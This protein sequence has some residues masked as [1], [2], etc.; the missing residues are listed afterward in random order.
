MIQ[1]K[2]NA[3]LGL[4]MR[5]SAGYVMMFTLFIITGC[6][7]GPNYEKPDIKVPEKFESSSPNVEAGVSGDL[8]KWWTSMNDPVLTSL[9]QQVMQGNLDIK[10]AGDRIAQAQAV[11]GIISG[12]DKPRVDIDG[13][14]VRNSYSLN[15]VFGPFLPNRL[16]ND[17]IG[18]FNARWELDLFGKT[19]RSVEAADAGVEAARENK[20]A[21]MLAMSAGVAKE[22]IRL[23]QFQK[24]MDIANS[25]IQIQQ[26]ILD[27]MKHRFDV[28]LVNKLTLQQAEAQLEAA[29][30]VLPQLDTALQQAVHRIGILAGQEPRALENQLMTSGDIPAAK[31][32]VP[33]GL[34]S[35]LL[36]RRPDVVR[37]ERN[38][39]TATANI[40]AATAD[41]F[42]RF[43][44]TGA[45]GQEST[46]FDRITSGASR[47][48]TLASGFSWP[49]L[50]S[51]MIRA[52]IRL[53]DARQQ[54]AMNV[55]IRSILNAFEDVENALVAYGNEQQRLTLL[56]A[57]TSA[58][59]KSLN[60][61]EERY[62]K[63]LVDFVN[64][65][66]ARRQLYQ[67][68]DA[69]IVSRSQLALSLVG[70]YESLGGG[71]DMP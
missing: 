30:S 9:V 29:R 33:I 21:V 11:R 61:A 31:P 51:G 28:G 17:F 68:E 2:H 18:G 46:S 42:P 69:L 70:L 60:L 1:I 27:V 37:A 63:G 48:W 64:V 3:V 26:N 58:K 14:A 10:V 15:S 44:L 67:S 6:R 5:V 20:R 19:A 47:Y 50:D 8:S 41:L 71:W 59:Q 57:E 39:A 22:Y 66:D 40:G 53:Q 38:L 35:E 34:P 43:S 49:V 7:V 65:L 24:R 45:L 25:N 62:D 16:E 13:S 32:M 55:Y 54:E 23:R 12:T 4:L 52:N 56:E 36:T